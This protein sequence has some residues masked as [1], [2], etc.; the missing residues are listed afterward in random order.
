MEYISNA[1]NK[2]KIAGSLNIPVSLRHP[3][4]AGTSRQWVGYIHNVYTISSPDIRD[5]IV[6]NGLFLSEASETP[7]L[8]VMQ[9]SLS[10]HVIDG[11]TGAAVD[12][13]EHWIKQ[14][15]NSEDDHIPRKK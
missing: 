9:P 11:R 1:L 14:I 13:I 3:T 15:I 4:N 8:K 7:W 6:F 10:S 5:T 2:I 12:N